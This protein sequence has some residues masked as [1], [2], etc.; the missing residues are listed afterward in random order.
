LGGLSKIG[1]KVPWVL[2]TNFS[3]FEIGFI[4]KHLARV[5]K[6]NERRK[7]SKS[8]FKNRMERKAC[9]KSSS[10]GVEVG[11]VDFYKKTPNLKP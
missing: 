7:Q 9:F 8:L 3:N 11:F 1:E 2:E 10:L 5:K 4:L 6:Q